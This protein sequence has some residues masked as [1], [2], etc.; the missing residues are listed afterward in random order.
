MRAFHRLTRYHC[1]VNDL[2]VTQVGGKGPVHPAIDKAAQTLHH[3]AHMTVLAQFDRDLLGANFT[4]VQ[5]SDNLVLGKVK[6]E[7]APGAVAHV[8]ATARR[9]NHQRALAR[10]LQVVETLPDLRGSRVAGLAFGIPAQFR[11]VQ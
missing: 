7:P 5:A 4:Q 3:H 9:G 2:E 1:P 6:N 8:S 10:N 11:L